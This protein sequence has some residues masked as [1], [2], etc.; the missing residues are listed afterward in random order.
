M[1]TIHESGLRAY[2]YSLHYSH[3]FLL[4]SNF[5]PNKKFKI[6]GPQSMLCMTWQ[7]VTLFSKKNLVIMN[8]CNSILNIKTKYFGGGGLN[9]NKLN[10]P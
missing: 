6:F 4:V 9:E 2:R 3:D 5:F 10:F 7:T 8:K 1:V